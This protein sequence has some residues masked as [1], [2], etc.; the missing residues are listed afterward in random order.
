MYQSIFFLKP[1]LLLVDQYVQGII[2]AEDACKTL[3]IYIDTKYI[4]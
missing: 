2:L 1:R 3:S 4:I